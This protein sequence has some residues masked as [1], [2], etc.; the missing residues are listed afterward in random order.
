MTM[1]TQLSNTSEL[2]RAT[3][4]IKENRWTDA[5]TDLRTAHER[6]PDNCDI[7]G[8][9]GFALSRNEQ[10]GEA[11]RV[12][13]ELAAKEP[14]S[15]KW[16]Y[17]VGYQHY[18]QKAWARA[19]E[20]F[21]KAL[22]LR[23][24]YVK[25]LYRKGYAY[26]AL[27]QEQEGIETLT[28][29]V[30]SWV[31]MTPAAQETERPS[32]GKAHFQLGKIYLKKGRAFKARGHLQIAAQID[33]KDHDVLYELGQCYLQLNL[34]DDAVRTLQTA[35]QIKPG[36]D[37]VLDRLAQAHA[38]KGEYAV[39]ERVYRRIPEHRRR[40]FVLQHLGMMYLEQGEHQKALRH[41]EA[42]AKKQPDNHNIHYAL[43][44]AQEATGQLRAAHASYKRAVNC[45]K[46]KYNLEFKQ[47]KDAI[48]RATERLAAAPP[49]EVRDTPKN[50]EESSNRTTSHVDL[51]LL[52]AKRNRAFSS[53]SLLLSVAKSRVKA[54][55][56]HSNLRSPP[57][58]REPYMSRLRRRQ[59]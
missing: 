41:L 2:E 30:S 18:Q 56:S 54:H 7:W 45:R 47:A 52:A 20:W 39:A 23:P 10:Y 37:Y 8:Q 24:G 50:N 21:E 36:T 48:Q 31:K 22:K 59:S 4:A 13:E 15:P 33:S 55:E 11:I 44:T 49:A 6:A 19:I 16:P 51:V 14:A 43:G 32:Y 42:A 5:I 17:M 26:L 3:Q 25:V 40:P 1:N 34:L 27:G 53:M 46:T 12:F 29:C 38:Q 28:S 58:D 35:D 9:L 57:K